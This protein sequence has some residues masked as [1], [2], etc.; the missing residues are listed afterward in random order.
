MPPGKRR[1]SNAMLYTLITFVGLFIVATTVAVIYYVKAEELRTTTQ[2]AQNELNKMAS[3]DEVRRVGDIVGTRLPGQSNL[4]SMV[5]YFNQMAGLILGRPIQVTSAEVNVGNA[6]KVFRSLVEQARPYITI[7]PPDPNAVSA[8][9]PNAPAP[10]LADP[11]RVSLRSMAGDLIAKVRQTTEQLDARTAQLA[12]LQQE[13]TDATEVWQE[14]AD[15][16][17]ARIGAY[18]LQ[19]QQT[20]ADYND[21]RALLEQSSEQRAANILKQLENERATSRQLNQDL[22]KTQAELELAQQRLNSALTEIAKTQPAP[23]PEAPAHQPDGKIILVDQAAGI[24]HINLGSDDR[25]YRGLTFSVYDKAAGIPRDGKPKAEIEVFAIAKTTATARI[26]SSQERNPIATDDIIANLI[27]DASKKNQFVIAGDFDLTGKGQPTYGARDRI[28]GLIEKWGGT[29]SETISAE[30]DFVI[31]GNEP[32]VPPEP[33]FEAVTNDPTLRD[34]YEAARK[35]RAYYDQVRQQ[36]QTFYIPVFT[37]NRFL[38]FIGYE[39]S[40]GKPGSF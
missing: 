11:N 37:F 33:T 4:G 27:W 16:L 10:S 36:A 34:K 9:D 7:A 20:K 17:N 6:T 30:T 39:S 13:F 26:L 15:E 2:E 32:R 12:K 1:Q 31:L 21:L 3:A 22:L 28:A 38:H 14:T 23:D 24:V 5:E 8:A 35:Q 29:T 18:Q 25:I 40:V 19:V